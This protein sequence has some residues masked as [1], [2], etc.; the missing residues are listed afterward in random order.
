MDAVILRGVPAP[1]C[2]PGDD[3]R[4]DGRARCARDGVVADRAGDAVHPE[5]DVMVA[6][7][8]HGILADHDAGERRVGRRVHLVDALRLAGDIVI[9]DQPV[10]IGV[11]HLDRIAVIAVDP[12]AGAVTLR[13]GVGDDAADSASG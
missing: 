3:D 6:V 7:R 9:L 1:H 2:R 5:R 11:A 4:L 12:S 10:G 13:D 8:R